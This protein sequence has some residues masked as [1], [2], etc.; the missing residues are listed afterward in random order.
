MTGVYLSLGTNLGD[1]AAMLSQAIQHIAVDVGTISN[2]SAI[3]ET[4]PW[5]NENQPRYL[6]Q[7]VLV[8]T[9]LRPQQLL[10]AINGIEVR[11]GRE[12]RIKWEPR[13]MDI[14]ILFYGDEV[15]NEPQLQ[16]PHPLLADRRFILVPL[17][18]IAPSF[19]HPLFGKT[20]AALLSQTA[21]Q[22]FVNR[23]N[24]DAYEQ[25]EF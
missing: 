19:V 22:L 2:I 15:I 13:P 3:Y 10:N 7:V 11:L 17:N 8:N 12:R 20:I 23:Y 16:V 21:D 6:N 1:R 5:G 25:Y 4:A 9:P 18:E 24:A 14:D